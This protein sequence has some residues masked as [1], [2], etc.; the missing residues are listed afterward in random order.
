LRVKIYLTENTHHVGELFYCFRGRQSRHTG[1]IG[2]KVCRERLKLRQLENRGLLDPSRTKGVILTLCIAPAV[3]SMNAGV[4]SSLTD[5]A[6]NPAR[7]IPAAKVCYIQREKS[8]FP[9][10]QVNVNILPGHSCYLRIEYGYFS[11]SPEHY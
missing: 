10:K 6:A 8:F 9:A 2:I 11:R 1:R 3:L 4:Q 5:T 7:V